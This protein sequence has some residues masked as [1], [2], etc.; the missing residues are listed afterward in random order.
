MYK[1]NVKLNC[2]MIENESKCIEIYF[3]MKIKYWNKVIII[4]ELGIMGYKNCVVM[5][6][7]KLIYI[8]L[9]YVWLLYFRCE[10]FIF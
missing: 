5:K 2:N 3:N 9:S 10:F 1:Y 7:F 8:K 6:N 4:Y